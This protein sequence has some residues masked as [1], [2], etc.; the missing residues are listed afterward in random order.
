MLE[1]L[2]QSQY[3]AKM[4]GYIAY[5]WHFV[6]MSKDLLA[7]LVRNRELYGDR[8]LAFILTKPEIRFGRPTSSFTP[9]IGTLAQCLRK[10]RE[11]AKGLG[12]V[13]L[14]SYIPYDKYLLG[15]AKE[16]GCRRDSW[17]THCIVF[18]KRI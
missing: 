17:G 14:G 5:K 10:V 9:L 18:E 3:V 16:N 11:T 8:R 7:M 4:N 6:K 2:L 13:S 15:L 12:R 1:L